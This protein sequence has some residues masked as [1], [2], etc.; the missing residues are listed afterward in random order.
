MVQEKSLK[1]PPVMDIDYR[2]S[3]DH[4]RAAGTEAGGSGLGSLPA[5][6]FFNNPFPI[7]DNRIAAIDGSY[8]EPVPFPRF[9][10]L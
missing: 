1:V 3:E 10:Y 9:L 5:S 2:A 7:Q 8:E 6:P 4:V